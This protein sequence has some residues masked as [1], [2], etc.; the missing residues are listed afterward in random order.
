[1]CAAH[2]LIGYR[3]KLDGDAVGARRHFEEA[4]ATEAR[5]YP[6]YILSKHELR[7]LDA[8]GE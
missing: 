2:F 7:R 3:N 4:V 6:G 8:T 1:M 5:R